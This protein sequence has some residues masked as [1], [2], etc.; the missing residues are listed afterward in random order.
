MKVLTI[1]GAT[2]DIFMHYK[3]TDTMTITKKNFRSSYMLFG[4]GEK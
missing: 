2:Q 4:S 1:G 3:G